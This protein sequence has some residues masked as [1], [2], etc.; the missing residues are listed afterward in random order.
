VVRL[1]T[2][3]KSWC[4]DV[5]S[6][7][8]TLG[9]VAALVVAVAC[10]DPYL[11]TNPYD[12]VYP[13]EFTITGPDTLFS[14]GEIGQYTAQINPTWADTGIVWQTDTLT[15][16][17]IVPTLC[18]TQVVDGSTVLRSVGNGAYES[19]A[20]PPE[21]YVFRVAIAV[22]LGAFDTISPGGGGCGGSSQARAWRHTAYKTVVVTQR[23]A[24]IQLSCAACAALNVGDTAF[25][26][27]AAFDALGHPPIGAS[28]PPFSNVTLDSVPHPPGALFPVATLLARDSTIASTPLG[29]DSVLRVVA[30]KSGTTWVVATLGFALDSL[31]IVVH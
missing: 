2:P 1:R 9:G 17:F 10:G 21:P 15:N 27:V 26:G 28:K 20:P 19:I 8:C 18:L 30:Q 7:R 3:F 13:V 14:F 16:Y 29:A 22:S 11:H 24:H 12:P 23:I 5:R 4:T 6:R 31:L 25:I